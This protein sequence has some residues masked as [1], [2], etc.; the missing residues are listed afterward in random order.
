MKF[1]I[2]CLLYSSIMLVNGRENVMSR[3][4]KDSSKH[5]EVG[6]PK[7]WNGCFYAV[8][9]LKKEPVDYQAIIDSGEKYTD[10]SFER[11]E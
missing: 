4:S 2:Q 3:L 6:L 7:L 5:L 9:R 10:K 11:S 1:V 8:N